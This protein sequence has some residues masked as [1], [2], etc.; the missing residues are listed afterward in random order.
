[1]I[2]NIMVAATKQRIDAT[3]FW[4][5]GGQT[6]ITIWRDVGR[7]N[8]IK[9]LHAEKLTVFEIQEHLAAGATSTGQRVNI[10]IGGLYRIFER[11]S[12]KPNRFSAEYLALREKALSLSREGR[13]TEW[14]A[15]HF[16]EQGFQSP[17][18]KPWTRDMVYGLL[19]AQGKKPISLEEI[20]REAITEARA[21][22]LNYRQMADE[23]NQRRVRRRDGQPWTARDIKK[24]WGDLNRLQRKRAEKGSN[25]TQV[26][27]P[28]VL[29][30]SA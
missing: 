30:K 25:T 8:L 23:F 14:I 3:I 20:H 7:Y 5:S 28:V 18:G 27:E 6:P 12:L 29:K 21:R 15:A 17:S 10:T 1:L 2:D 19:R 11:L 16:N 24:R 4:K 9:E 22:R 13:S 26:S